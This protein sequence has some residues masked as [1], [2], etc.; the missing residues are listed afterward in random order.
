MLKR[1]RGLLMNHN[2]KKII[3]FPKGFTLIEL[4]VAIVILSI[5]ATAFIVLINQSTRRSVDPVI[6]QQANAIAQS[7]LEEIMLNP[8]C[9]PDLSTDCPAFCSGGN[10]CSICTAS[11]ASRDVYDDI[12]DYRGVNDTNG[13]LDRDENPIAGLGSYNINITVNDTTAALNGLSAANNEVM[14]IDV[15]VTHDTF[16]EL[17]FNLSGYRTNY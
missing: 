16:T 1:K 5:G 10:T 7:Y 8:F 11:E 2:C 13:A 12:C 4:V 14:R 9:D 15:N 3:P 17:D 6:I